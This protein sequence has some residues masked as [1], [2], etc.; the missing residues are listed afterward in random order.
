[1]HPKRFLSAVAA[2]AVLFFPVS[3]G[4][5][6]ADTEEYIKVKNVYNGAEIDLVSKEL[7]AYLNASSESEQ[8]AVLLANAGMIL[9]TQILTIEWEKDGGFGYAVTLADNPSFENATVL[10]TART[11]ADIGGTLTPGKTYYYKVE[12]EYKSGRTDSFRV[13]DLPVRTIS[14]EGAHN[15]RDLGG[16]K[17]KDGNSVGYG[18]LYRGG[19][20]NTGNESALTES[21]QKVMRDTLGIRTE[22]D[23]RFEGW[24]DDGQTKSAIGDN[25]KYVKPGGFHSYNYILPEF[26]DYGPNHRSYYAPSAQSLKTIFSV[27]ADESSYPVYFHCNAGADRTGVLAFLIETAVGVSEEDA[28]RDFELT[29]FSIYGARYRGKIVDGKFVGGITQDDS[30]NFVAMGYFIERLKAVYAPST[31]DVNEAAVNYLKT[32]CGVTDEELVSLKNI[33]LAKE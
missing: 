26:S 5:Q 12:G 3:C 21:G 13:K 32:V 2:A 9:D 10:K 1:M 7:R 15:V 18:K 23:L 20:I 22:I 11:R 33:L 27:L 24:D 19:K 8:A 14:V 29:S 30:D 17:T 25:V 16:W 6:N 28:I 31:G 4:G